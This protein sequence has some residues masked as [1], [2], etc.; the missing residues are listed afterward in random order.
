MENLQT[1]PSKSRP[2]YEV[3]STSRKLTLPQL[4]MSGESFTL[5]ELLETITNKPGG[6]GSNGEEF[7]IRWFYEDI[8]NE[9]R[10]GSMEKVG[11]N[12]YR[13]VPEH[14]ATRET[15][16]ADYEEQAPKEQSLQRPQ[17]PW[18]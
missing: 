2:G 5:E 16:W 9:L 11:A 8:E 13:F 18:Y 3:P 14:P 6:L 15:V 12:K 1:A 7:P 4:K 10:Q 17:R